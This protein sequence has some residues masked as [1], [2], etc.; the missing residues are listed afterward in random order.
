[1]LANIERAQEDLAARRAAIQGQR[2]AHDPVF[3]ERYRAYLR[4]ELTWSQ[5]MSGIERHEEWWARVC[6]R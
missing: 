4:H 6:T 2:L 1:M 5:V 3:R